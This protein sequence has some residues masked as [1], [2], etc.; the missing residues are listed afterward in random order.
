MKKT[1]RFGIIG[2]LLLSGNI[3]SNAQALV[4]DGVDDVVDCGNDASF[5]TFADDEITLEAWINASSWRS[6]A[7]EGTII[8]KEQAF[9]ADGTTVLDDG[10]VLRCG[11]NGDVHFVL[12]AEGAASWEWIATADLGL[13]AETW[14]HLAAVYDG[15]SMIIYV[16]GVEV[17]KEDKTLVL[18]TSPD[19]PVTIGNN[20]QWP[21]R[22]FA[23][24]IDEVR[25]WNVARTATQIV[26]SKDKELGKDG[27]VEGLIAY[28]KMN[29]GSGS[30]A[31]DQTNN[32]HATFGAAAPTWADG[33]A[34]VTAADDWI[35]EKSWY[36]FILNDWN[37]TFDMPFDTVDNKNPWRFPEIDGPGTSYWELSDD[38][39]EG[40]GAVK[41]FWP[42][43]VTT[44]L[45]FD[46]WGPGW[47]GKIEVLPDSTYVFKFAAYAVEGGAPILHT[48]LGF[49]DNSGE[50]PAVAGE[51]SMDFTLGDFYEE[52]EH[53]GV[54]PANTTSFWIGFRLFNADGSRWP[55]SDYTI[56][57][58]EVQL[59]STYDDPTVGI[60]QKAV[61]LVASFYPNPAGDMIQIKSETILTGVTIYNVAGQMVKEVSENFESINV[62]ELSTGMYFIKMDAESGSS[63]QKMIKR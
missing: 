59:L 56:M 1:L 47:D 9:E 58:D 16:D 62:E 33:G 11:G 53:V 29:E 30:T 41:T 38:S 5:Q 22:A 60:G 52:F 63:T 24:T 54:A 36:N 28:Y 37:G 20:A 35:A 7:H 18:G 4:F 19:M 25:I 2:V 21:D 13:A 6:G 17:L 10:Y 57:I 44:E 48:T 34:P 46:T 3:A 49:F 61:N 50:T 31:V 23:G 40:S 43:G 51:T 39:Y 32:N 14:I 12:G 15:T 8:S 55:A 27:D 26:E 45:V 42:A